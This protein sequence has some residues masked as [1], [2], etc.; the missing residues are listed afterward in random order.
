[1]LSWPMNP[2]LRVQLAVCF[3][4]HLSIACFYFMKFYNDLLFDA[5]KTHVF[6]NAGTS[7]AGQAC[8]QTLNW[9]PPICFSSINFLI[10]GGRHLLSKI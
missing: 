2:A 6:R 5:T 10:F 4:M 8:P 1:M 7:D 3:Y 9:K